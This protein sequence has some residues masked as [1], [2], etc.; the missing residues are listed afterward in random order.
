MTYDV[1]KLFVSPGHSI[2]D[3]VVRIDKSATGIALVVDA[4]QG[5]IATITDGDIRRGLLAGIDLDQTVQVLLDRRP[6]EAPRVP[7]TAPA[8]SPQALLLD[9]MSRE[10]L[11]HV[12]LVD[13]RG[14]VVDIALLS[15][16][17]KS[18]EPPMRALVMAGGF[19]TRLRPLTDELPKPMLPLGDRPLLEVIVR[20]L[21]QAGIRHVSIS[22]HYKGDQIEQHFG[23]GRRFDVDIEYVD[24]DQPLGTAGALGL[25]ANGAGATNDGDPLLVVNGDVLTQVNYAAM[26]E[27]HRSNQADLTVAVRPFEMQVP[28]GVV[29]TDGVLVRGVDEKPVIRNFINAGIYLLNNRVCRLVPAGEPYDMTQLI[30]RAIADS[31]RVISFPLREYWLDIGQSEDYARAVADLKE[32]KV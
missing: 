3:A 2:R 31:L 14:R 4:E 13:S 1:A 24:E 21:H 12:P 5:L 27:F 23:D 15:D 11:R 32:G 7:T 22:R 25:L 28:Y 30:G 20:Q 19:G 9:L 6:A 8:G 26:L 17:V 29:D 10:A 16:F 18:L